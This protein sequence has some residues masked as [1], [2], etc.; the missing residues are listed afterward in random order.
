MS[1]YRLDIK[2]RNNR[3]LTAIEGAGYDSAAAFCRAYAL[4]Y[5]LVM[6]VV[7]MRE[8]ARGVKG[9]RKVARD[10]ADA[11]GCNPEDLF[12][13]RQADAAFETTSLSRVVSEETALSLAAPETA[14][15]AAPDGDIDAVIDIR[16]AARRLL[17]SQDLTPRQRDVVRRR[18]GFDGP[19][20]TFDQ[21]GASYGIRKERVRQIEAGALRKLKHP[22]R[23]D[24]AKDLLAG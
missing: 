4:N 20:E 5:V 6:G 9:W 15:L 12:T 23:S 3:V 10:L 13:D 16:Q 19:E 8:P 1:D 17:S 14:L 22:S 11:L 18:F 7:A 24:F 2:V 21:I